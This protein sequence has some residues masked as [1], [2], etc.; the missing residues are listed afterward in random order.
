MNVIYITRNVL[1]APKII[2]MEKGSEYGNVY[3]KIKGCWIYNWK[4]QCFS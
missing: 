3:I 1:K 4:K 2:L